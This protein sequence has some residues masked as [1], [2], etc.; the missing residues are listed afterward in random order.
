M[1]TM[2]SPAPK[3]RYQGAPNTMQPTCSRA[4]TASVAAA[5]SRKMLSEAIMRREFA[6]TRTVSSPRQRSKRFAVTVLRLRAHETELHVERMRFDPRHVRA[7]DQ[8]GQ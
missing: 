8:R 1:F 6:R 3:K 2:R 7:H 5:S 4:A